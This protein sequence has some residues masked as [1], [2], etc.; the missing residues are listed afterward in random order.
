MTTPLPHRDSRSVQR[1]GMDAETRIK[2]AERDLDSLEAKIITGLADLHIELEN[3]G[4]NLGA[5]QDR[6]FRVILW[7]ALAG[8]A[9]TLGLVGNLMVGF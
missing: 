5:K 7:A 8:L 6:I 4:K 1:D 3:L 2:L 9:A